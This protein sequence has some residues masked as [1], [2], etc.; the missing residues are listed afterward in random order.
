MQQTSRP[1]KPGPPRLSESAR[2]LSAP[3]G[4]VTTGWPA[5]RKTCEQKLGVTFDPWQDG[6]GR[7]ILGKRADGNLAAMIDGVG[8]SLPRQVGKTYLIGALVFALCVNTPGLLVIWTAHHLKTSAETFLSLQGFASR[9]RVAPFVKYVHT[10]SGD[11]EVAFHNGSRILFGARERGFGRGI[12]GVDVLI[13]DEAQILSDK[14]LANMLAT[15]N[16]SSF[17][18]QLYIGTPP[19]PEDMSESFKRMRREAKAGTLPDGAWVEFGADPD[20]DL[21]DHAQWRR[22]NPS[23]PKRTP[24]Q[25]LLRLKRKLTSDD[26]R[27]EG[28]GIWDDDA[29]LEKSSIDWAKWSALASPAPD[30]GR[31]AYAVKFS[32]DGSRVAI[33]AAVQPENGVPHV[34]MVKVADMA[35]GTSWLVDWLSVRWQTC[36]RI[37]ID[38]AAGAGALVNA[39]RKSKVPERVLHTPTVGEVI[40]AHSMIAEAIRAGTLSHFPEKNLDDAVR[41]A[42]KRPIGRTGGW[43]WAPL[44]PDVDVTPLDVVTLALHA[45]TTGKGG[46]GRT[47]G[48]STRR[49]VVM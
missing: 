1:T 29:A 12:P 48:D 20:A 18:L 24:M 41:G 15:L 38:G 37:T 22:A 27:R 49:A 4:I 19:K 5:I 7:L 47:S 23:F 35:A 43:G 32:A 17:G 6:A 31:V 13:F 3:A 40:E 2:F 10:G 9:Q 21:N 26:W 42:G 34:E 16:T 28:M 44:S 45:L 39:L 14:A 8:M 30:S 25:S 33:G 46:A 11:E 36:S